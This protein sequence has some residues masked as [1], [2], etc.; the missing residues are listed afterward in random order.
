MNKMSQT[1]GEFLAILAAMCGAVSSV[2]Y[3]MLGKRTGSDLI[4]YVRMTIA[5]PIM[6]IYAVFS[7][8]LIIFSSSPGSVFPL[9]ISGIIGFFI[10]DLFMFRAYV[11]WGARE[12]MA[13]MCLAPVLSGILA[14]A[15][16]NERLSFRQILGSLLSVSGI[17]IMT[18]ADRK[19]MSGLTRGAVFALLAAVLQSVADMYAKQ[20]LTNLPWVSSAAT[21]ALGGL[22]A[23]FVFAFVKRKH[24]FEHSDRFRDIRFFMLLV[25]TVLIGT[26]AGTT[27]AMGALKYAPAGIV[28]SLKQISPIFILPYEILVQK[29]KI[30]AVSVTGTVISVLGVFLIF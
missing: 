19:K 18:L 23:W 4:A 11:E 13:V 24:F 2:L 1:F 16:F 30:T 15:F 29:K 7:D 27:V 6:C 3:N 5:V 14:F 20:A 22:V 10:T 8:G 21:R 9:L 25:L 17:I 26:V 12:T 28:T